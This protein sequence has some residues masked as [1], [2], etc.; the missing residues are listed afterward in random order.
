AVHARKPAKTLRAGTNPARSGLERLLEPPP[1]VLGLAPEKG[2]CGGK[3]QH[4]VGLLVLLA[5]GQG[6]AEIGHVYSERKP[7]CVTSED[8]RLRCLGKVREERDVPAP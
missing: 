6:R 5:K 8:V 4:Q 2:E 3:P 7:D 1:P